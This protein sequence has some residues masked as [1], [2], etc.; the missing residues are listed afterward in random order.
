MPE[1]QPNLLFLMTD[2]QRADSLGMVQAGVEVTPN[3][4]RLASR[5]T[6][7]ERA[8]TT[9]PLCV[10]A[11]TA[12][13][14][15]LYPTR[16]GVVTNDWRGDSA[17]DHLT[18]HE[19]LFRAGYDVAHIGVDHIRVRPGLRERVSFSCWE[20]NRTYREVLNGCGIDAAPRDPGRFKRRVMEN[21]EG[22]PVE[23]PYSSTATGV[24]PGPAE[25][26][27]DAYWCDRAVE[28]LREP[29]DKPF[30]LFL[31]LWAPHPP[32]RVPE[33][34]ASLF[35]PEELELPPNVGCPAEGAPAAYRT[36]IASQ[37]AEGVTLDQ[38]RRVWAAHLGL[39]RLADTGLGRVL[40]TLADTCAA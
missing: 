39:V 2:H 18:L 27:K 29:R 31:Y 14:T 33:P 40:D 3:L 32:L 4:N 23:C 24:W 34:F 13:A 37:L 16:N 12:L 15:G 22:I 28:F 17:G 20:D 21:H 30:A 7:F 6:S 10:P 25:A 26:F 9:C 19:I 1:K 38:W 5:G 36:G 11:R 8:Y 35:P